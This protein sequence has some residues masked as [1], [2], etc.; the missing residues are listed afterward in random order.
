MDIEKV[1]V[2]IKEEN[3]FHEVVIKKEPKDEYFEETN[4]HNYLA[5][6]Q[7]VSIKK[8]HLE[9]EL[10]Q[11]HNSEELKIDETTLKVK[12]EISSTSDDEDS[13]KHSQG[14]ENTD[15]NDTSGNENTSNSCRI[16]R[17]NF[18]TTEEYENHKKLP[19]LQK[20]YKCCACSKIF[21]DFT[22]LNVHYRKHTGE[23]PYQ[24]K[25]CGKKFSINGNLNKHIRTH[26]GEK[27]FE[28]DTCERKFTQFAH[29]EDHIKTH[30]GLITVTMVYFLFLWLISITVVSCLCGQCLVNHFF[31][32]IFFCQI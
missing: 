31:Y 16:C 20:D 30:T 12:T 9:D 8:E 26:T 15:E 18:K 25:I 2:A 19:M 7:S 29:L 27:R 14:E 13:I 32:I 28:C 11:K 3:P 1:D 22:Q 24:C 4:E 17:T 21:K 5:I 23:K 10:L 6:P